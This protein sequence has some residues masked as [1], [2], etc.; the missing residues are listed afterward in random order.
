MITAISKF[1]LRPG[2]TRAQAI[3][4]IHETVPVY[5]GRPGL[6]RKYIALDFE[7]G[8]GMGIYLWNERAAAEQFFQFA[9][10]KIREQTGS[11]PEITLLD[12]PVIVDNLTGE[13]RTEA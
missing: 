6:V 11:D 9:R 1:R 8:Y 12:T 13:V 5:K 7:A 10:A 4:E 3:A 2:L